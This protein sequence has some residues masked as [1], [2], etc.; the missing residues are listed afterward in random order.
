MTVAYMSKLYDEL[1]MREDPRPTLEYDLCF[2][3]V[4][5]VLERHELS[6]SAIDEIVRLRKLKKVPEFKTV[7]TEDVAE[8]LEKV[9]DADDVQTAGGVSKQVKASQKLA[10][11]TRAPR[12][13]AAPAAHGAAPS[14]AG[15][16]AA[17]SSTSGAGAA[18]GRAAGAADVARRHLP[19][20]AYTLAEAKKLLP[21]RKG[22][23]IALHPS[24]GWQVKYPARDAPRSHSKAFM[25]GDVEGSYQSLVA[26]LRWAWAEHEAQGFDACRMD[27]D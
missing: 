24:S 16:A 6:D 15:S 25:E 20:G 8:E 23:N 7:I 2:A 3:I 9:L 14:G 17:S 1:E 4:K 22:C 11:K 5:K 19:P 27:L 18:A 12:P 26:G 21:K 10:V 13:Q